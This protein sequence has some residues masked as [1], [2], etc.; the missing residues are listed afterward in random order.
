MIWNE[1]KRKRKTA[2]SF[3]FLILACVNRLPVGKNTQQS[4][5][6]NYTDSFYRQSP[7]VGHFKKQNEKNIE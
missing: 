7:F 5:V 4:D 3:F 1:K 6:F 2:I